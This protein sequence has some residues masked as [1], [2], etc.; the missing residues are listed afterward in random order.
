MTDSAD[1]NPATD[2]GEANSADIH[3][4]FRR[5]REHPE[6]VFGTI[7]VRGDFPRG[8]VP[9]DFPS[10][11]ATDILAERG[12]PYIADTVGVDEDEDEK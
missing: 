9:D 5:V 6:F 3:E 1:H 12:N 4:M 8:E 10:K 2:A 7:F 11:W